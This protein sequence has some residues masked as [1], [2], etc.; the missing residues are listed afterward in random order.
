MQVAELKNALRTTI[1]L[2][3]DADRRGDHRAAEALE[4]KAFALRGQLHEEAVR[5]I[6]AGS[7]VRGRG[8]LD[9]PLS[10][11]LADALIGGGF[12]LKTSPSVTVDN[13]Y[14]L[15]FK[16]GG[17]DGGS[18]IEDA[19]PARF[20]ASG[21]GLDARYVYPHLVTQTA[22]V[23][24]TGVTS[25]RQKSRS[26]ATASDMVKAIDSTDTKEETDTTSEVVNAALKMIATVSTQTPNVLLNNPSFRGW[27]SNDLQAAFRAA[28]DFHVIDEIGSAGIGS[29]GGGSN[30]YEDVL[31]SQEVVRA[32]GYSPDLVVVS[33]ADALAIQLLMLTGGDSYAFS[34]PAPALVVSASVEDG[35]GFVADAAALGVLFLGPFSFQV[36][37]ENNGT[38]NTS[39]V[40]GESSGLFV[41]QRPD[42]AATLSSS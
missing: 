36:F 3:R 17:L 18:D 11:S 19:V 29:G 37:E 13:R 31:Y 39:T 4:T 33:P 38:T 25:Y 20:T 32:A 35:A 5:G 27:V 7:Y 2:A 6:G 41:V 14:A 42:A 28:V 40:R 1:D 23:D 26:L 34:T 8:A 12:Q 22:E 9:D 24:A 15:E 10:G 21:L 30:V 16:S